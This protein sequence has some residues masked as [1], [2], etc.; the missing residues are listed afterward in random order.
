MSDPASQNYDPV[1]K[2]C[3]DHSPGDTHCLECGLEIDAYG[4]TEEEMVYCCFPDCGCDGARL[5]MAKNGASERACSG[6]VEGMWRGNTSEQ[7]KAVFDLMSS[8]AE[9]EKE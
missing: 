7:R 1:C 5:C 3:F 6:N 8:L 9:G 4:N 2:E